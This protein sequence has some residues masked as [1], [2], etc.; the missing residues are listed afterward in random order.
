MQAIEQGGLFKRFID[1][2]TLFFSNLFS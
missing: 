2:L 1:W